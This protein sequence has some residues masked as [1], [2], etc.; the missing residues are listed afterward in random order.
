MRPLI[1]LMVHEP[2]VPIVGLRSALM[3]LWQGFNTWQAA[4]DKA[5]AALAETPDP[6]WG[7]SLDPHVI[8]A[9]DAEKVIPWGWGELPVEEVRR[10]LRLF[11]QEV[12]L[13]K[14]PKAGRGA[15]PVS[16][17]LE[18]RWVGQDD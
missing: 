16:E 15:P 9:A 7:A 11:V 5:S 4:L 10:H 14:S 17:R 8:I 12:V 6:G 2:F 1:T 18:V 3:G 13:H